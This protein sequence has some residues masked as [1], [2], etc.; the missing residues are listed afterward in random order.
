M[1]KLFSIVEKRTNGN[2]N[3]IK[4]LASGLSITEIFRAEL[5]RT[6]NLLLETEL[7]EFLHYEKYAVVGYN[8]SNSRNGYYERTIKTQFG[9]ITARIPRDRNSEFTNHTLPA[10]RREYGDLE[11]MIIHLYKKASPLVKSPI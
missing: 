8:S 11:S 7:T 1:C 2:T 3:F 10:Y 4:A 6:V 9:E 5:E